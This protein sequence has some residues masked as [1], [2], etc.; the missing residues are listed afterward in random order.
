MIAALDLV[1]SD[2]DR[3]I[4]DAPWIGK[5]LAESLHASTLSVRRAA[6]DRVTADQFAQIAATTA[7]TLRTGFG[8]DG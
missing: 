7:A 6:T 4:A 8:F 2:L 3:L 1:E 5:G